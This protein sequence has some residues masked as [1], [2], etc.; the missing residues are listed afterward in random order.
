MGTP[1][2][3]TAECCGVENGHGARSPEER[4]QMH[5]VSYL[6]S[7]CE[8]MSNR[9]LIDEGAR[10][11]QQR[12]EEEQRDRAAGAKALFSMLATTTSGRAKELVKQG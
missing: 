7:T 11:I 1:S 4:A 5:S 9:E 6:L 8:G 10:W 12:N 3:R 2:L